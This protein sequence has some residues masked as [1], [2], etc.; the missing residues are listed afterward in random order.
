MSVSLRLACVDDAEEVA[1]AHVDGWR[2]GYR[3]VFPTAFLDGLSVEARATRWRDVL[4]KDAPRERTWVA[5]DALG[6]VG[7]ASIGPHR[8]EPAGA[9]LYALYV[10]ERVAGSDVA[11]QLMACASHGMRMLDER[12]AFLWV[13]DE[14]P[15]ARRFYEREGWR[16]DGETKSEE[17]GGVTVL[18][19]RYVLE[20][21]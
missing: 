10:L 16:P 20:L 6:V 3:D 1:R 11:R 21:G 13:L 2:W 4:G 8:G 14:N 9:E 18:E 12:R 17:I 5:C 15:R 7:F 19:V